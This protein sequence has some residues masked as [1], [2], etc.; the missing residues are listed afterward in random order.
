[1]LYFGGDYVFYRETNSLSDAENDYLQ[2]FINL[3]T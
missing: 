3:C 1:V 2:E